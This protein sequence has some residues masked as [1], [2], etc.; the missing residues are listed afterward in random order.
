MAP[1]FGKNAHSRK[2]PFSSVA[3]RMHW[4]LT[5]DSPGVKRDEDTYFSSPYRRKKPELGNQWENPF[6]GY[7]QIVKTSLI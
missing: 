3:V 4:G 5:E 6:A 2:T 1:G 7:F